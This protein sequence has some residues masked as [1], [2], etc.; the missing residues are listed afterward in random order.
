VEALR[1]LAFG[2]DEGGPLSA[3]Y[4][5][6]VERQWRFIE[7]ELLDQTFGGLYANAESDSPL[8]R[9]VPLRRH[10]WRRRKGDIWKDGSHEADSLAASVAVLRRGR[11]E[12]S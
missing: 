10:R 2:W 1:A 11:G 3:A 9:F 12:G 7:R 6:M 5:R 4:G 8:R